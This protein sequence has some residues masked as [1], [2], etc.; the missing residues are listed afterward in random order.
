MSFFIFIMAK[1]K[2]KKKK[3]CGICNTFSLHLVY[4]NVCFCFP[5]DS[6]ELV[7]ERNSKDYCVQIYQIF[8]CIFKNYVFIQ[9]YFE[10]VIFSDSTF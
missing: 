10:N 6:D 5:S 1:K 4:L 2:R 9:L 3:E 7:L 8:N